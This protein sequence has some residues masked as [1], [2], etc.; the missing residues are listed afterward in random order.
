MEVLP[1]AESLERCALILK[2]LYYLANPKYISILLVR[3]F[4]FLRATQIL[5]IIGLGGWVQ[6]MAIFDY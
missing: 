5:A 2:A 6:K 4:S 1:L 3:Y